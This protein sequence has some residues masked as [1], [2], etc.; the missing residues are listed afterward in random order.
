MEKTTPKCYLHSCFTSKLSTLAFHALISSDTLPFPLQHLCCLRGPWTSWLFTINNSLM[1]SPL[2]L[3]SLKLQLVMILFQNSRT[4]SLFSAFTVSPSKGQ[5]LLSPTV[6]SLG[7]SPKW[8]QYGP[9]GKGTV[10]QTTWTA[11]TV[12]SFPQNSNGPS[13]LVDNP[14]CFPC[15]AALLSS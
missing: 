13:T 2:S 8:L 14:I 7:F 9:G 15:E 11:F 3:P 4:P 1:P 6:H 12:N 5:S 10:M